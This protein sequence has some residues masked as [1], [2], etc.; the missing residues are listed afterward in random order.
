[1]GGDYRHFE[2]G[3]RDLANCESRRPDGEPAHFRRAIVVDLEPCGTVVRYLRAGVRIAEHR[4]TR[5]PAARIGISANP[6]GLDCRTRARYI[7]RDTRAQRSSHL[8]ASRDGRCSR[9]LSLGRP[10]L[11]RGSVMRLAVLHRRAPLNCRRTVKPMRVAT[12]RTS[13]AVAITS[14]IVRTARLIFPSV[15]SRNVSSLP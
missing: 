1:V 8:P 2:R 3:S 15:G 9:L 14:A 12:A 5:R 7:V 4:V 11:R 13:I 10:S 6:A